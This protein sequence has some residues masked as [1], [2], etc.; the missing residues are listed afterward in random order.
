MTQDAEL[1]IEPKIHD[2]GGFQVRRILPS[3]RRRMV[4]P[5]IFFDHVGPADFA[6]GDGI[7]VRP[8]PHIGLATV[9]YLFEGE[10]WHRD[11]LGYHQPIE[12]GAVNWMTAGRGIVHSEMPRQE[13]GLMWGFQLWVNLPAEQK[14]TAPRYQDIPSDQVPESRVSKGVTVK[15]IAGALGG[16]EGPIADV[17][18]EPLYF[19]VYMQAGSST[20]FDVPRSHN[21]FTYVYGG[22]VE[23]GDLSPADI[24]KGEIALLERDEGDSVHVAAQEDSRFLRVA[25]K[26]L[27]EPIARQGPFVM[28]TQAELRQAFI[29]F[30]SGSF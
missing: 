4:G 3:A 22:R 11:S 10:I 2:L 24:G 13:D 14:M 7:D 17:V 23:I 16:T 6:A 29:D 12:P 28:T 9:T 30:R 27:D 15:V 19:D 8:H 26:P 5:F 21:A 18:T 1:V 20:T 25:G